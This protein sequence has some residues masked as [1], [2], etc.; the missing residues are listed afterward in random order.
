MGRAVEVGLGDYGLDG[1]EADVSVI[2]APEPGRCLSRRGT[3]A[4]T[5]R[6]AV[7]LPLLPEA[8]A[9]SVPLAVPVEGRSVQTVSRFW[10]GEE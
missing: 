3:V 8:V 4:V 1:A 6:V 9:A 5:V 7:P 10:A 2:C